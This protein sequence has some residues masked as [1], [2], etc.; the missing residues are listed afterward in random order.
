MVLERFKKWS[1]SCPVVGRQVILFSI[2]HLNL[3]VSSRLI[4]DIIL[5]STPLLWH[6]VSM[7]SFSSRIWTVTMSFRNASISWPRKI[8]RYIFWL[9]FEH[10][11]QC[12]F[13]LFIMLLPPTASKLLPIVTA[14]A[15]YSDALTMHRKCNGHNL[16]MRSHTMLLLLYKTHM[17]TM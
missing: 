5:K 14:A 16:S 8:I 17:E 12:Y 2:L 6:S 10:G 13:S 7:L 11:A 15:C 4:I 3:Q 1:I 9:P